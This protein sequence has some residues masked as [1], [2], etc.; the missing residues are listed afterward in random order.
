MKKF[1]ITIKRKAQKTLAKVPQVYQTKIIEC[2][3]SLAE[4]PFPDGAK[5]LVD[6]PGWRMRIGDYRVIYEIKESELIILVLH[7]G[8]RKDIYRR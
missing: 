4:N 3:R 8:H 1:N 7:I 5:K 2:I 6:R